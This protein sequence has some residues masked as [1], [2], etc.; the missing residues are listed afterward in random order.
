MMS[1]G[2]SSACVVDSVVL[3]VVVSGFGGFVVEG[4]ANY[5]NAMKIFS[6]NARLTIRGGLC[7]TGSCACRTTVLGI[8]CCDGANSVNGCCAFKVLVLFC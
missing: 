7:P 3:V 5:E 6:E 2:G 4:A 1:I 8:R